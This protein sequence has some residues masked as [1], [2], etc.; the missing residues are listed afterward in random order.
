MT[1]NQTQDGGKLT[2]ALSGRLDTITAPEL[3][4]VLDTL[5]DDV[6]EL[7]YDMKEL[8]YMSS[9]GLRVMLLSLKKM[10]GKGKLTLKNVSDEIKEV[11]EI[12]QFDSMF[13]IE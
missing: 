12:T 3:S 4:A 6:T 10:S 8:D 7:V 5:S 11:F 2:I 1:I 9:A 13:D